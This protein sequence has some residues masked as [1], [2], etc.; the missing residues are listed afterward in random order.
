MTTACPQ[1][2]TGRF[3]VAGPQRRKERWK[4]RRKEAGQGDRW[5]VY[6]LAGLVRPRMVSSHH[7]CSCLRKSIATGTY[8][9]V[10]V[11]GGIKVGIY[12]HGPGMYICHSIDLPFPHVQPT[13]GPPLGRRWIWSAQWVERVLLKVMRCMPSGP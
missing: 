10:G 2:E 6:W 1:T 3:G 5:A 12:T 9:Y 7:D 8:I 13:S 11:V 4:E